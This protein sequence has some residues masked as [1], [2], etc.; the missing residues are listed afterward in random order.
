MSSDHLDVIVPVFEVGH[1]IKVVCLQLKA[2]EDR[3][4]SLALNVI[5]QVGPHVTLTQ[6]VGDNHV[7]AHLHRS[8]RMIVNFFA[9]RAVDENVTPVK[10]LGDVTAKVLG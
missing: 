3:V 4:N 5:A 10:I 7:V 8:V 9:L 6:Q 2:V 1:H